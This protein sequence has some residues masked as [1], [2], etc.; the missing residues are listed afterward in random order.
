MQSYREAAMAEVLPRRLTISQDT[1]VFERV[2]RWLV[3]WRRRR[4]ELTELARLGE[5]EL[6]DI[7]VT[8]A[9]VAAELRK[10][11]WRA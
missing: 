4:R 8:P 11:F 6:R 1:G 7:G 9:E 10:P 3:Q 2:V 5:R